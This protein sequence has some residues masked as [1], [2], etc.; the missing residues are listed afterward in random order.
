MVQVEHQDLERRLRLYQSEKCPTCEGP[1]DSDFHNDLK[2]TLT[3]EKDESFGKFT[4]CENSLTD[5]RAKESEMKMQLAQTQAQHKIQVEEM[6]SKISMAEAEQ[7]SA[8]EAQAKALDITSIQYSLPNC[9]LLFGTPEG[10]VAAGTIVLPDT[11]YP[12]TGVV[13]LDIYCNLK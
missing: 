6:K 12:I 13:G 3:N 4:E 2:D 7:K 10:V 9:I 8:L 5:V 11:L 1:L